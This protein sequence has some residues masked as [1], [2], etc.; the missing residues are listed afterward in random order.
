MEETEDFILTEKIFDSIIEININPLRVLKVL[1][2]IQNSIIEQ[3]VD[4]L[5]PQEAK[6]I[7]VSSIK[8]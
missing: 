1:Q 4:F 6:D 2:K 5:E 3:V 7:N 8:E